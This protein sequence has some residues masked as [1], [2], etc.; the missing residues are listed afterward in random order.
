MLAEV[1]SRDNLKACRKHLWNFFKK[2][3]TTLFFY[4]QCG[5]LAHVIA[6]VLP[7]LLK[8]FGIS[9]DICVLLMK[10]LLTV[11]STISVLG[12]SLLKKEDKQ[13]ELST[14]LGFSVWIVTVMYVWTLL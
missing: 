5:V 9:A 12:L 1:F 10:V 3:F 11:A 7:M 2:L 13:A 6:I 4:V 8:I 14:D